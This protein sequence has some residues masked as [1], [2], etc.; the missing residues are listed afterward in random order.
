MTEKTLPMEELA[1]ALIAL[2]PER[3]T[4]VNCHVRHLDNQCEG[5]LAYEISCEKFPQEVITVPSPEMHKAAYEIMSKTGARKMTLRMT[6][7]SGDWKIKAEMAYDD[8][9]IKADRAKLDEELWQS[10]YNARQAFFTKYLGPEPA[11]IQKVM[12]VHWTGGGIFDYETC[13]IPEVRAFVSCGLSNPDV[14]SP[15]IVTEFQRVGQLRQVSF[16]FKIEPRTPR[17]VPPELAGYGYELLILSGV[18]DDR[19][20]SALVWYI[21]AEINK[22]LDLLGRVQKND[23]MTIQDISL[24]RDFGSADFLVCPAFKLIPSSCE[25]PNGQ[26][27]VLVATHITRSEMD[28]SLEKGRRALIDRLK[29]SEYGQLSIPERKSVI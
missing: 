24:G 29:A 15:G 20:I 19:Y 10:V 2:T 22:D 3:F 5:R 9:A 28:F 1:G 7:D 17:Y 8:G 14:P 6:Q 27:H 21:Q 4:S 11:Q 16:D 26:M 23:G 13:T 12:T 25:L 18:P